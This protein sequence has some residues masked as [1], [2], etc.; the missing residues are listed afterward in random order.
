MVHLRFWGVNQVVG[1]SKNKSPAKGD[2][3]EQLNTR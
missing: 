3:S 1:S 2:W